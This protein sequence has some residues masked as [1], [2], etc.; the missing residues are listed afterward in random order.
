MY[1]RFFLSLLK[2]NGFSSINIDNIFSLSRWCS[3]FSRGYGSP[4]PE[5]NGVLTLILVAPFPVSKE[6][7]LSPVD[8][9]HCLPVT[10]MHFATPGFLPRV[11]D[12]S[13]LE[14]FPQ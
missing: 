5:L 4:P 7:N 11:V 1:E 3:S 9:M 13:P 12:P 10:L 14:I 2:R 6:G 8:F